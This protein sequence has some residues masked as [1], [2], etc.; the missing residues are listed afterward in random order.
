MDRLLQ[1][2]Y[3]GAM[4][5][6]RKAP[7]GQAIELHDDEQSLLTDVQNRLAS[8]MTRLNAHDS[9]DPSE[10]VQLGELAHKLHMLL[11]EKG[12]EP[13]HHKYMIKNRGVTP[14]DPEFYKH[15][16]PVEDL[17]RFVANQS[18]N[19]DPTDLTLGHQF[20]FWVYSRRFSH[21]DRYRVTRTQSG[22]TFSHMQDIM[23][24]R[25]GRVGGKAGTGLFHLLDH[26]SINYPEELPG[27]LEW[28]WEQ[29]ADAGLSHDEVQEA[30]SDLA[31]WTSLCEQHS[32]S[33][34]FSSFK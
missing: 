30:L 18:S 22:W 17:L 3:Y 27:Y 13:R 4:S 12:H 26:D 31:E 24:G 7:D 16:H 29:A 11:T 10:I 25:D 33:G 9:V 15:V 6:S 20:E 21:K 5:S 8:I 28:L 14:R 34:V 23:S 19:D 32:P 1:L 2:G